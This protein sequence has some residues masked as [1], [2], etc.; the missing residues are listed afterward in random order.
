MG[1]LENRR[2]CQL[3]VYICIR[4]GLVRSDQLFLHKELQDH[5]SVCSNVPSFFFF[6]KKFFYLFIY[7][8]AK[9]GLG[10]SSSPYSWFRWVIGSCPKHVSS[11]FY[12][13]LWSFSGENVFCLC[14]SCEI[15]F[16][17][18][19]LHLQTVN[20]HKSCPNGYWGTPILCGRGM[21][22]HHFSRRLGQQAWQTKALLGSSHIPVIL[23]NAAW[24]FQF[25][26][27]GNA[28][29]PEQPGCWS[30]SGFHFLEA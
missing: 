29:I 1:Q 18:H 11:C 28:V 30:V 8:T 7:F 2:I 26:P 24:C 12:V 27:A 23:T 13:Y 3:Y 22:G 10:T 9:G 6:K 5:A 19:F 16:L 20:S 15:R 21:L 25:T 17:L 14:K 4:S